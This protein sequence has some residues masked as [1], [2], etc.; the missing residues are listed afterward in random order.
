MTRICQGG[1]VVDDDE[2]GGGDQVEPPEAESLLPIFIQKG[3]E[4]Y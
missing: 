1:G 2:R 4:S 3:A